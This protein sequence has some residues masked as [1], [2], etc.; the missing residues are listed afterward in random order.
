MAVAACGT[1]ER[2]MAV[3]WLPIL[4]GTGLGVA[5]TAVSG[6]FV[7]KS[8]VK[9]AEVKARAEVQAAESKVRSEAEA[10]AQRA[11]IETEGR[12]RDLVL[13][14]SQKQRH[15]LMDRVGRVEARCDELQN[16][17]TVE[18]R[19]NETLREENAQL[20]E[21]NS[22]LMERNEE[23]QFENRS[24]AQQIAAMREQLAVITGRHET[25]DRS[26]SNGPGS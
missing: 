14:D 3:D 12:F 19:A 21:A 9:A 26:E 7:N 17:L 6:Y 18:R 10:A 24:W 16:A 22:K 15:D 2:T 20:R 13:E 23:L 25:E 5:I 8:Q 11:R 1:R 4:N